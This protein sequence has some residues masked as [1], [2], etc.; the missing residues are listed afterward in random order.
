VIDFFFWWC[1][2]IQAGVTSSTLEEL[3]TTIKQEVEGLQEAMKLA[4]IVTSLQVGKWSFLA[5]ASLSPE[6]DLV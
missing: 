1:I 4:R 3:S 6:P 2:I 5:D